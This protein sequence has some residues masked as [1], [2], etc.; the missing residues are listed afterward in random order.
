MRLHNFSRSPQGLLFDI[1]GTLYDHPDYL[2]D[3]V[4][5]L[6][7]RLARE[8][9]REEEEMIAEVEQKRRDESVSS[10]GRRPSLGTTF[11]AHYGIPVEVSVAWREE[12]LNPEEYLVEDREL[13]DA[14][15]G[16][17]HLALCAVTNNPISLGRRTLETLGVGDL[18]PVVSGLDTAGASK[19][20]PRPFEIALEFLAL[21]PAEILAI[22][23]RYEIDLE[24]IV[25]L[26]GAGALVEGRKD[27]LALL[28]AVAT[29]SLG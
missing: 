24:P 22:G 7:R 16:V 13:R 2:E 10:G 28:E 19:P 23:D 18:I 27:L 5:I 11:A 3:Q 9:G 8:L 26:G 29:D 4:L 14:L 25:E 1:D 17:S 20:D 6:I 21:P 15:A 12:L